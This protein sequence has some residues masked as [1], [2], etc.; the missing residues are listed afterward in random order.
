MRNDRWAQDPCPIARAMSLLGQRW[1]LLIIR[2][3]LLG[4]TRFTEFRVVSVELTFRHA[5]IHETER[6]T[7]PDTEFRLDQSNAHA[8]ARSKHIGFRRRN[9]YRGPRGYP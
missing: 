3:A 2:E 9:R 8:S 1:S 5:I 4:R 7:H 6:L